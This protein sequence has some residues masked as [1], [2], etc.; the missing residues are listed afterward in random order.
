MRQAIDDADMRHYIN[1]HQD[2]CVR[3]WRVESRERNRMNRPPRVGPERVGTGGYRGEGEGD[4]HPAA[5]WLALGLLLGILITLLAQ[6]V[7]F[8]AE[9]TTLPVASSAVAAKASSTTTVSLPAIEEPASEESGPVSLGDARPPLLATQ[10]SGPRDDP[11]SS[12]AIASS[13]VAA[14]PLRRGRRSR[15]RI[16]RR[17]I[18]IAII[19]VSLVVV[20]VL[21]VYL[22]PAMHIASPRSLR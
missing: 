13:L 8:S 21:V 6:R 1:C 7:A 10:S 9:P 22:R 20:A 4:R 15:R 3:C 14:A 17:L 12:V 16:L 11:A 19:L 5:A 18:A 2:G